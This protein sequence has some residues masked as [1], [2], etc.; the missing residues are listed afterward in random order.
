PP[1]LQYSS[2]GPLRLP[3]LQ[4]VPA[5][6]LSLQ[7]ALLNGSTFPGSNP[8]PHVPHHPGKDFPEDLAGGLQLATELDWKGNIRLCILLADAPCHGS[9]Y[10]IGIGDRYPNGC[11]KGKDPAKLLYEL[12][13]EIGADFYF[14]RMTQHTDKMIKV[15]RKKTGDMFA[16]AGTH[17]LARN[18]G[19]AAT[20]R[21]IVVHDLGSEDNRFLE[22][23]VE[24][25]KV[26]VQQQYQFEN[27]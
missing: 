9:I 7:A 20:K 5:P 18:G 6:R 26:S 23:V 22:V 14:I 4:P 19:R 17:S 12:Q 16:D 21:D 27:Y 10:H 13:Y 24:S 3:I 11:P 15:L 1:P 8:F 2:A 25:V